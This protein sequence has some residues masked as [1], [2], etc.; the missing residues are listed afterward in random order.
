[1]L[2]VEIAVCQ[3]E[4]L[5]GQEV[6]QYPGECFQIETV[7]CQEKSIFSQE[8]AQCH[9]ERLEIIE[10][11]KNLDLGNPCPV[12]DVCGWSSRISILQYGR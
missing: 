6:A 9:G 3:E 11:G 4:S 5:F 12:L 10:R 2:Q 1:M 8:V 7:F